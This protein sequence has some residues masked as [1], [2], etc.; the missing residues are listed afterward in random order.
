VRKIIS[1]AFDG[2]IIICWGHIWPWGCLLVSPEFS[3]LESRPA[4][5]QGCYRVTQIYN[6]MSEEGLC[7]LHRNFSFKGI[8]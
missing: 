4:L 5:D 2:H 7:W 3:A 1:F 6:I 8:L